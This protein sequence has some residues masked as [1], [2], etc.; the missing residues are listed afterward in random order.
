[1]AS[2]CL[3]TSHMPCAGL[4]SMI[5]ATG[6]QLDDHRMSATMRVYALMPTS[7]ETNT[8]FRK[9]LLSLRQQFLLENPSNICVYRSW[10]A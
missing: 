4:E 9:S 3:T 2:G 6:I 5:A 1:M 10:S 8:L 7:N